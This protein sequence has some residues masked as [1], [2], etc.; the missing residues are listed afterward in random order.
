MS[1][2]ALTLPRLHFVPSSTRIL[3][4]GT[5]ISNEDIAALVCQERSLFYHVEQLT[6]PAFFSFRQMATPAFSFCVVHTDGPNGGEINALSFPYINVSAI[7]QSLGDR[8]RAWITLGVRPGTLGGGIANPQTPLLALFSGAPREE[9]RRWGRRAVGWVCMFDRSWSPLPPSYGFLRRITESTSE[10]EEG[11]S[12]DEPQFEIHHFR[13]FIAK[14]VKDGYPEP[15]PSDVEEVVGLLEKLDEMLK[16]VPRDPTKDAH[17]LL[18]YFPY[19]SLRIEA[20]AGLAREAGAWRYMLESHHSDLPSL[21][22][23][24]FANNDRLPMHCQ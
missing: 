17:R 7:L 9:G 10:G 23:G 11:Q 4:Y 20:E 16:A 2:T 15:P 12:K 3:V 6:H 19:N 8:L 1:P 21:T 18:E 13:S 24:W 5:S 22:G 14:I